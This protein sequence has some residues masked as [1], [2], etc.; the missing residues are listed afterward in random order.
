[1]KSTRV[2]VILAVAAAGVAL[3]ACSPNQ[4]GAAAVVGGERISS[5]E[6]NRNVREY[7]EALS[8]AGVSYS[9]LQQQLQIQDGVSQLVLYQ[10]AN[11]KRKAQV[12]T[13]KGMTTTDGELDQVIASQGGQEKFEQLLLQRGVAPSQGRDFLR[14]DV[15]INKLVAKYGGGT[16]EAAFKRGSEQ[17]SKDLQAMTITWNPRYGEFNDKPSQE[18]SS[19]FVDAGRFGATGAHAA[20]AAAQSETPQQ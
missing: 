4:I 1:M 11:A 2:R 20:P 13:G 7:E 3:T 12:A 18:R 6:L 9:Q 14:A 17:A 16:D 5:G 8:K 10:L 19:I 15:L